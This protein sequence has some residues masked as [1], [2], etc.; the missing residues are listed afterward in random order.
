MAHYGAFDSERQLVPAGGLLT[1]LLVTRNSVT[2]PKWT[3]FAAARIDKKLG[4]DLRAGGRGIGPPCGLFCLARCASLY[5]S[6]SSYP[7]ACDCNLQVALCLQE[8]R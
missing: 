3:Y 1:T 4:E 6:R 8:L 7:M 2:A 5:Q